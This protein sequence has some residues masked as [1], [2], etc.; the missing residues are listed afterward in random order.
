ME[1]AG[2]ARRR[3]IRNPHR[4]H[5][6]NMVGKYDQK[7]YSG[8]ALEAR[9]K[10]EAETGQSVI[11]PLNAKRVLQIDNNQDKEEKKKKENE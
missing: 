6:P 8:V 7:E 9:L 1:S 10:L 11:S 2:T 3:A 5:H 4:Y